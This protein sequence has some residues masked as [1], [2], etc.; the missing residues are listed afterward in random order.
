MKINLKIL[1]VFITVIALLP[2][3]CI[4]K[5]SIQSKID[6]L[7]SES[8]KI[9][10][11]DKWAKQHKK[12]ILSWG[13]EGIEYLL[14]YPLESMDYEKKSQTGHAIIACL[15]IFGKHYV[16]GKHAKKMETGF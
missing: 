10:N 2:V 14:H 7:L 6:R 1:M 4:K 8:D 16:P 5:E 3:N 15:D 11:Y 13:N 12:E 9:E